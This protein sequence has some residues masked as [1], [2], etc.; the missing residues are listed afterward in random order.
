[1]SKTLKYDWRDKLVRIATERITCDTLLPV[2]S[3]NNRTPLLFNVRPV[4]DHVVDLRNVRIHAKFRIQKLVGKEWKSL[5]NTDDEIAAYNNFGYCV[6]ED[7]QLSVNGILVETAQ[8]EYGRVSYLKNLL[9]HSGDKAYE[10]AFFFNDDPGRMTGVVGNAALNP[11]ETKRIMAAKDG[12]EFACIAPIGLDVFESNGYFPDNLSFTLRFFPAKSEN[13][14]FTSNTEKNYV[15]KAEITHAELIVPRIKLQPSASKTLTV[16]YQST[17][18]LTY[19]NPKDVSSFSS[20]LNLNQLPSKLAIVLLTE[21]QLAGKQGE[22][23]LMF[24]H[25]D[26]KSV[27]VSCNGNTYP[28]T[29]RQRQQRLPGAVQCAF[30]RAGCRELA[31]R[32]VAVPEKL[33]DLRS[34]PAQ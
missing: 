26:V 27:K 24:E 11:G 31:I 19:I 32:R 7:V 29:N 1:M 12:K 33:C 28:D 23:S 15:L 3:Q 14:V 10:A 2:D 8:R 20:S 22:N 16:P 34:E 4:P 25:H 21:S 17:K 5:E 9:Y 18:V 30:Q 13:C 6:F